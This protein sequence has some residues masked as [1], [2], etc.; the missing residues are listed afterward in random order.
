MGDGGDGEMLAA[1]RGYAITCTTTGLEMAMRRAGIFASMALL[2]ACAT[3]PHQ[4]VAATSNPQPALETAATQLAPAP[5][6]VAEPTIDQVYETAHSGNLEGALAM[7]DT[8]LKSHP[9]SA[10]VH[11]VRAWV[12]ARMGRKEDGRAELAKARQLYPSLEFASEHSLSELEAT[13]GIPLSGGGDL[14][15]DPANH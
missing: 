6:A 14:K 3:S 5:Q 11:F 7:T 15:A 1:R 4:P 10:K 2:S 12:L 9:N 13:L 8:V